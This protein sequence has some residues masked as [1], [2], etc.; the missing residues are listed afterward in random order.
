MSSLDRRMF[1]KLLA[2]TGATPAVLN[3]QADSRPQASSR[4]TWQK[5][6]CRLCGV[7]CGMLVG[8]QNGR[9]VAVKGD[10]D[11]ASSKGLACVKGYYAVQAL[12]G[13]DRLRHALIRRHGALVPVALTEAYDLIARRLREAVQR[14]G[15]G[16]VAL[17]G[18]GQW[19]LT[20][21]Y[22]AG[23][24]WKGAIGSN[25]IDTSARLYSASARMGALGSV[26]VDGS[27]NSF[28]DLEHA[29]IIVL[30]N[31]NI[32][33]TDPV[34]FSR[35]LA[36]RR[37]QRVRVIELATRTTR[38]SYGVDRS[39][40]YAP[41]AELAI[42][43]AI[44][45]EIVSRH[46]EDRAFIEK[47]AGFR[48]GSDKIGY[49]L[50][51]E[52]VI[53]DE[54]EAATWKEYGKFLAQYSAR[55]TEKTTGVAPED[56]SWLAALYADRARK[57]ISIWGAEV[58]QHTRGT[59]VNNSIH[60]IH[61]LVGKVA[62]QGN[63]VLSLNPQAHGGSALQEAGAL[64]HALPRGDVGNAQ[65]RE[66]AA[67][68]WRIP[69][70]RIDPRP[71][72]TALSM[73]RALERGDLRFLW[74]QGSNP[75][76]SLPNLRRYRPALG[77]EDSFVVVSEAYPTPTTDIADVVLPA[78]L[79]LE[80]AAIYDDSGRRLQCGAALVEPPG[81]ARADAWHMIEIARRL[82]FAP[83]FPW[84]QATHA[85]Q[86]WN[87]YIRFHAHPSDRL[88]TWAVLRAGGGASWPSV[89]GQGTRWRCNTR[90]DPA[91]DK[92][93]GDFDF[94]GHADHRAWIWLRPYEP[95]AEMPDA[96]YPFWLTTG[97][98]LEHA[99]TGS[100]TRRIPTLHRAVPRAYAELNARDAE[101]L[102]IRNGGRVRLVSRRGALELPA[103]VN[104][105][106]Q[107]ARGQVFVPS[108]DEHA[109][110]NLL[111]L[112]ACCPL[113]GQPDYQKCAVR[114]ERVS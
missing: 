89:S 94:Y 31:H 100:L 17:Y 84:T 111:T 16:S 66:L 95:P 12:Y 39:I 76:V 59:W 42:A 85:E 112:D 49:G 29:D 54:I 113:S 90:H 65:D 75:V 92:A 37:T 40:R 52:P 99:G 22:V 28:D 33:E 104:M 20:D 56:I 30:W 87:E 48:K 51:E 68:I 10:V 61:L 35:I 77:R 34:L 18:S 7:G 21:A 2:V 82:G 1:L 36:R 80:R 71:G 15:K 83:M 27:L 25:H 81:D 79:W 103:R 97:S 24:F 23:K 46:A 60:N 53:A 50:A 43:H 32:A 38:T 4:L 108:F 19:S 106:S 13:S 64:P 6:S 9:A 45:H 47:Y 107:P 93:H 91:A 8:I 69:P 109:P 14:Y 41:H 63:G 26:G 105:R 102:G 110:I 114:V 70:G 72:H 62:T 88:P 67:R 74:I 55:R 3:A 98:V 57:V 11:A 78:A 96:D 5:T 73:F 44:S 101:E 58:N 86:S